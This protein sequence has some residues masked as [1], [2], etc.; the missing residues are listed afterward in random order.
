M[1][2]AI[3][4]GCS[5]EPIKEDTKSKF[6]DPNLKTADIVSLT[7]ILFDS[8]DNK[9]PSPNDSRWAVT[10]EQ[11]IAFFNEVLQSSL[12]TLQ[13]DM[14]PKCVPWPFLRFDFEVKG[15]EYHLGLDMFK[16]VDN[17]PVYMDIFPYGF[18]SVERKSELI[19][20]LLEIGLPKEEFYLPTKGLVP[21]SVE[22]VEQYMKENK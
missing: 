5:K 12:S 10:N 16:L 22:E 21:K 3:L 17:N 15:E 9:S 20:K 14:F 4:I 13:E 7:I 11:D 19:N 1:F 6:P 8:G 18:F 2:S